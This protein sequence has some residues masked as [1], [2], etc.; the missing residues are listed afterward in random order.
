MG[1]IDPILFI[2]NSLSEFKLFAQG[3]LVRDTE[4]K[5]KSLNLYSNTIP[6]ITMFL[7][8]LNLELIFCLELKVNRMNLKSF[9]LNLT[10]LW[11]IHAQ[12]S[13]HTIP[14]PHFP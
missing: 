12:E 1:I 2:R 5:F 7:D 4:Y 14:V 13:H 3:Y 9:F 10:Y 6:L 8:G 11:I